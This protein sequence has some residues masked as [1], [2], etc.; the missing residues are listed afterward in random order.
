MFGNQLVVNQRAQIRLGQH[1]N[2]LHLVRRAE[3]VEEM[4]E[5]N[6]RPQRG[7]LRN[8]REIRAPPARW[9]SRACAQP[10]ERQAMM[11]L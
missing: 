2:L 10:V 4:H 1:L 6:P 8:Q 11:S 9:P 5:R 3:A 7:R